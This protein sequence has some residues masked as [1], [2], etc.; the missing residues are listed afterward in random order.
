MSSPNLDALKSLPMRL[1][2]LVTATA[3]AIVLMSAACGP[4]SE[5]PAKTGGATGML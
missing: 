3:C 4:S 5:T 1:L 2:I